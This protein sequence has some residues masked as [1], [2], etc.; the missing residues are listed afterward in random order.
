MTNRFPRFSIPGRALLLGLLTLALA[1]GDDSS[2]GGGGGGGNGTTTSFVGILSSD[3]AAES[4]SITLVLSTANPTAPLPTG[5]AAVSVSASGSF[6]VLGGSSTSL[7]GTYDEAT[8]A[9]TVSG[10][11]YTFTGA[12]DGNNRL[13][14]I[15]TGTATQGTFVSA[16]SDGSATAFCGSYGGDDQGLWN[17]VIDGNKILGQAVSSLSGTSAPLDGSISGGNL[18]ILFPGTQQVLATG[19]RNGSNVSGTWDDPNSTDQGTW[20][21]TVCP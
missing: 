14:G 19:T 16:E 9:L 3:D 5:I 11:G 12:F 7:A 1:C 13:E 15:Y 8:G 21:G 4:G 20:S 6:T 17:F 18:S 2:G 10:G